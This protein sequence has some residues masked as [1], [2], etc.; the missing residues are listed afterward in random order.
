MDRF[1]YANYKTESVPVLYRIKHQEDCPVHNHDYTELVVVLSG[2]GMHLTETMEYPIKTGDIF[3]IH[4]N[5]SHGY[6]N[7]TNMSIAT[8][9]FNYS[10]FFEENDD[11]ESIPEFRA[12]FNFIP[13]LQVKYKFPYRMFLEAEKFHIVENLINRLEYEQEMK[14]AGYKA[15]MKT[16]FLELTVFLIRNY[17]TEYNEEHK[18]VHNFTKVLNYIEENYHKNIEAKELSRKANMSHRNFQREFKKA[19]KKTPV[20]YILDKKLEKAAAMLRTTQKSVSE[21]A[22]ET[23]FTDS[24]YF[25]RQFKAKFNVPPNKY[26]QSFQQSA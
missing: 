7:A 16:I 1:E 11:F 23:G 2:N 24:S 20:R 10:D 21:I 18:F 17:R 6:K 15:L 8:I 25:A 5:Q 19:T 4:K 3:V 13:E 12:L 9:M 26:K 22:L 14:I